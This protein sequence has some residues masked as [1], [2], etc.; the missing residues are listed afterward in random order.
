[1]CVGWVNPK[2]M[3]TTGGACATARAAAH[4]ATALPLCAGVPLK[5]LFPLSFFPPPVVVWF[6]GKQVCYSSSLACGG[7]VGSWRLQCPYIP[8]IRGTPLYSAPMPEVVCLVYFL[9][10]FLI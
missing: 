9:S 3:K 2:G 6:R 1:M 10:S 8:V 4:S 5:A 7:A